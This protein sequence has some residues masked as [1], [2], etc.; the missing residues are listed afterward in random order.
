MVFDLAA[1]RTIASGFEPDI[2]ICGRLI[3]AKAIYYAFPLGPDND[4]A[5]AFV[6]EWH[7]HCLAEWGWVRDDSD[8]GISHIDTYC[9][10]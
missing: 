7:D 5:L 6:N 2:C 4:A 9:A 1:F 3:P 10:E 8:F